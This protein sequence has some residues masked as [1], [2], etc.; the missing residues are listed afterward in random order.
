MEAMKMNKDEFH[1]YVA[2]G[3]TAFSVV[4]CSILFFYVLYNTK[5]IGNILS[6][7]IG[8]LMPFI[9]GGVIAYLLTPIA[10]WI[11]HYTMRLLIAVSG[12]KFEDVIIRTAEGKK[13]DSEEKQSEGVHSEKAD[14]KEMGG[15]T[16]REPLAEGEA[17]PEE[18]S[19]A[20]HYI[21]YAGKLLHSF[22]K[23]EQGDIRRRKYKK[24]ERLADGTG[25][26]L[27][28]LLAIVIIYMLLA[29]VIPEVW[30][31]M[32][33]LIDSLPA[34]FRQIQKFL[35]KEFGSNEVIYQYTTSLLNSMN[36]NLENFFET[37][38]MPNMESWLTT[39]SSGLFNAI[40]AVKNILIGIIVS[41]Y[42]MGRRK[43]FLAQAILVLESLCPEKAAVAIMEELDIANKMFGGFIRGKLLDSLL[44][45]IICFV[46][47]SLFHMPYSLLI[48]VVIGVTNIIPFFGPFIGAVP[49]AFLVLIADVEGGLNIIGVVYFLI[50]ILVLQ[51]FDGNILGPKILGNSTGLSSFWVLFSILVFGGLFGVVGMVIGVPL[52][53]VIYDLVKKKVE[54]SLLQKGKLEYMEK[55]ERKFHS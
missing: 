54:K 26:V 29:T 17:Q 39:L 9:I 2:I 14:S 49:S 30:V 33:G 23:E 27:S 5:D 47:M 22:K 55:Y 51:Q 34:Y 8:I 16:Q 42:L 44:I 18:T 35:Q 31:S 10:N 40:G 6:T 20:A 32:N 52:F 25:I 48:S 28:L 11:S 13:K 45:G 50:F 19:G 15:V 41:V 46:F 36:V 21:E 3:L 7:I 53:A 43:Q 37:Y 1:K 24:I 12:D 38:L 4:V